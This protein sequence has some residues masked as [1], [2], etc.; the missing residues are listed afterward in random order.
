MLT[1]HRLEPPKIQRHLN[2]PLSVHSFGESPRKQ[3]LEQ[4]P[5]VGGDVQGSEIE[6]FGEAGIKG[7]IQSDPG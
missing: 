3:P 7:E 5:F 6:F 2:L 4:T 1:E